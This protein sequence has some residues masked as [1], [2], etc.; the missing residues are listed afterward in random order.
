MRNAGGPTRAWVFRRRAVPRDAGWCEIASR[1]RS[2][3]ARPQRPRAL[4]VHV[5]SPRWARAPRNGAWQRNFHWPSWP[6]RAAGDGSP[7]ENGLRAR[8]SGRLSIR[9]WSGGISM[10][11][12]LVAVALSALIATAAQEAH[13]QCNIM[14]VDVGG[15]TTRCV[16]GGGRRLAGGAAGRLQLDRHVRG[17]DHV[18]HVHAARVRRAERP[19]GR[20]LQRRWSARHRRASCSIAGADSVCPERRAPVRVR[21][22]TTRAP[23]PGPT[24]SRPPRRAWT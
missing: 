1:A 22:A 7:A 16:P 8:P 24:A 21:P 13:G 4:V 20:A 23:G 14:V 10:R 2:L 18:R 5:A 17:R 11:R 6:A 12:V 9:D 3:G 19:V 15:T